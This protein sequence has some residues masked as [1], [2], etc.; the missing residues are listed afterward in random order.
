[1]GHAPPCTGAANVAA[2]LV[3]AH[4]MAPN[5]APSQHEMPQHMTTD[6]SLEDEAMAAIATCSGR[7][8]RTKRANIRRYG[9]TDGPLFEEFIEQLLTFSRPWPQRHSVLI[10]HNASFHKGPNVQT[11]M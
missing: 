5:L 10:M 8:V 7:T 4:G 1:M 11:I 6:G 2:Y 3:Y 9:R